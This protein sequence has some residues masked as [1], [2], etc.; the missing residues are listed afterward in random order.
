ML[1]GLLTHHANISNSIQLQLHLSLLPWTTLCELSGS[2]ANS[3]GK[4][5]V[6]HPSLP[7]LGQY[8]HLALLHKVS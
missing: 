6:P 3:R 8:T 7:S 5:C 4:R 1:M 2:P